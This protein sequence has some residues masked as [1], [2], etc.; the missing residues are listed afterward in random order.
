MLTEVAMAYTYAFWHVSIN[1]GTHTDPLGQYKPRTHGN[2]EIQIRTPGWAHTLGWFQLNI[3][4]YPVSSYL[5]EHKRIQ[6][7]MSREPSHPPPPD[8][9][10]AAWS[11]LAGCFWI[12]GFTWGTCCVTLKSTHDY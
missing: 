11:Y 7:E 1:V 3:P 10:W 2:S 6:A 9:G 5:V 12:E 8:R 4:H